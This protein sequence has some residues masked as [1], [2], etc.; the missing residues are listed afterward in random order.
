MQQ[1]RKPDAYSIELDQSLGL[2]DLNSN[3]KASWGSFHLS[4][5]LPILELDLVDEGF[6]LL[7][8]VGGVFDQDWLLLSGSRNFK[9]CWPGE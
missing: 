1:L 2:P 9:T 6:S 7:A 5:F 3:S 8:K 4:C